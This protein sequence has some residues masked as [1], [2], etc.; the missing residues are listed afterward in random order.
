MAHRGVG[1]YRLLASFLGL[2][3][4][5]GEQDEDGKMGQGLE[6]DV[7]DDKNLFLQK[8]KKK[9]KKH[10]NINLHCYLSFPHQLQILPYPYRGFLF[11]FF[12]QSLLAIVTHTISIIF[13]VGS[14]RMVKFLLKYYLD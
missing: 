2:K 8:E 4:D 6:V 14:L 7:A 10:S 5:D 12:S 3:R 9:K 1:D 11:A 13:L